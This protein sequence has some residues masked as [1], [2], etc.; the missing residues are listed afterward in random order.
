MTEKE[1]KGLKLI[2]LS[3]VSSLGLKLKVEGTLLGK[4]GTLMDETGTKMFEKEQ[5]GGNVK[6]KIY[7]I[8]SSIS[9]IGKI[10]TLMVKMGTKTLNDDRKGTKRPEAYFI[11]SL[12]HKWMKGEQKLFVRNII[13]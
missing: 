10:G 3:L 4:I 5:K 12:E 13:G 7:F 6:N 8:T 1:Q 2:S 9:I 11:V